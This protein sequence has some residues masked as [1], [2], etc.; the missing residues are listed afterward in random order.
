MNE[1]Y[2]KNLYILPE[3]N[4]SG[5]KMENINEHE[6]GVCKGTEMEKQWSY[7]DYQVKEGLKPG[8]RH[9]QYFFVVSEGEEKKCNYCVWIEDEALSRF[10]QT[11]DFDAVVSSQREAWTK[12]VTKKIDAGDFQNRVLKFDKTGEQEIDLSEM[13][14]HISMDS[15]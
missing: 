8:S 15:Q 4:A 10:D 9:F 5:V 11:E 1:I 7:K 3:G 12:W 14:K 2:I 13:T 6:I